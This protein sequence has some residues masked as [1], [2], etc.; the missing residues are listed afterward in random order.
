MLYVIS[1]VEVEITGGAC[2]RD[3]ERG[4][5]LISPL[6]T[7]PLVN[8]FKSEILRTGFNLSL[9]AGGAIIIVIILKGKR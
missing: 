6:P 9:H 7:L 4:I 8:E 1:M 3:D 2:E 5:F